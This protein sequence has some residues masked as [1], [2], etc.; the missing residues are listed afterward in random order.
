MGN[1]LLHVIYLCAIGLS[2]YTSCWLLLK[3]D[4]SDTV[5]AL[6]ACQILV[7]VWC[8]P[9]LFAGAVATVGM[10]YLAY[11]ISY[12]GIC[13]IGPAWLEF[14]FRYCR[15][16][17]GQ[18]MRVVLFGISALN[19]SMFLCNDSYHLFYR[20]FGVD[21][22]VYGPVF[23]FH[24]LYTYFC[25]FCGMLVVLREFLRKRVGVVPLVMILL[26]AAVPLGF[27]LL[28]ISG[29]VKSSFDL[30]PPAF[31]LSS[32]LML[33]A[34]F[35]YDFL[36]VNALT[37]GQIFSSIGEG[38]VVYNQ[39]GRLTYCNRSAVEWLGVVQ[40]QEFEKLEERMGKAG[41]DVSMD[42]GEVAAGINP[43]GS[44][45]AQQGSEPLTVMLEDGTRLRVRQYVH[46]DKRG[47]MVAGTFILTD[48]SEYYELLRQGRELEKFRGKLALEQE[49][50]RIAQEVHDTT[51]HTLTM[52][53]S[54]LRLMRT[55]LRGTGEE[56]AEL[57]SY[58]NQAQGLVAG[59][60]RELRC[61]INQMRQER[62][63]MSVTQG[64]RQLAD[65][66]REI[67]VEVE[68]QGEDG[69]VFDALSPIVYSCL[70][71]AITNCLKYAQA[72]HMD[73]IVKFGEERLS[74][75]IFDDGQG[76]AELQENHGIRGIRERAG[77]A[78]GTVRV[79]TAEGEGFQIYLELPVGKQE[80]QG[81]EAGQD[82]NEWD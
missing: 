68:V 62:S 47:R 81:S 21:R 7:I 11:G 60:I 2:L 57:L 9:Q 14:S 56:A 69:E 23:Y 40:G 26:T 1:I 41:A 50:N 45:A 53:Q 19:F 28:Y 10:K 31:A 6:A 37:F 61:A 22:V 58:V 27:N 80:D 36:D 13:F 70:R 76:C 43:Q 67:E 3:A 66:V 34:V 38:V 18:W 79:M 12:I 35:R 42:C 17:Y 48:V 74:L 8:V 65:S 29:I 4:R 55:G 72:S 39:R 16:R 25:V 78:G 59:G 82:K 54:L 49:R 24:M 77:L 71:E 63:G 51:G 75:Y 30:T 44:R 32:L 73:V 46:R 15:R 52:V 5:G 64:I 33:L 20:Y